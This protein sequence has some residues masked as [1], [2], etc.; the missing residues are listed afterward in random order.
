MLD[1]VKQLLADKAPL[2]LEALHG[3]V[4]ETLLSQLE[5]RIGAVLP[6]DFK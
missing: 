4:D 6:D 2:I 5:A 1:A 3:P